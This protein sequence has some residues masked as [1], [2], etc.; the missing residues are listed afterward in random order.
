MELVVGLTMHS[1]A[2]AWDKAHPTRNNMDR[3][4]TPRNRPC[5]W[6]GKPVKLGYIHLRCLEQELNIPKREEK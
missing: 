6:C 1:K 3:V 2:K 4:R 5:D